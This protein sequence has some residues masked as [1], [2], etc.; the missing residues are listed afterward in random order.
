MANDAPIYDIKKIT[1]E[2]IKL[3]I[4]EKR[5]ENYFLYYQVNDSEYGIINTSFL[6]KIN[7][8][9]ELCTERQRIKE[10]EFELIKKQNAWYNNNYVIFGI[11]VS[12]VFG[13]MIGAITG[14]IL[15]K[16]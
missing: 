14:I 16:R 9:L 11:P 8:R 13:S 4:K 10:D 12:F 7:Y 6:N 3:V 2:D 5:P 15:I 1:I